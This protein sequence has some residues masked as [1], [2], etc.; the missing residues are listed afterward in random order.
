MLL[1]NGISIDDTILP[2]HRNVFLARWMDRSKSI[3]A[4]GSSMS[5]GFWGIRKKTVLDL[6][7]RGHE[8]GVLFIEP[9]L[10][11]YWVD[12]P[13]V[14]KVADPGKVRVCDD[15]YKFHVARL[16]ENPEWV[17]KITGI[18]EESFILNFL[19]IAGFK[20]DI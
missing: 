17:R 7:A 8:W 1:R 19:S 4:A 16:E 20:G 6:Q 11:A 13:N 5:K 14:T 12:A 3:V 15:D 9:L 18:D 10:Q 2:E